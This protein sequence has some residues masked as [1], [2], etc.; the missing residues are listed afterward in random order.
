MLMPCFHVVIGLTVRDIKGHNER[1]IEIEETSKLGQLKHH[2][3]IFMPRDLRKRQYKAFCSGTIISAQKVVSAARCFLTNRKRYRVN[4]SSIQVV[5]AI[6]YTLAVK[7]H[8]DGTQQWRSVKTLYSPRYFRYPAN[9]IALI[10]TCSLSAKE[11][12]GKIPYIRDVRENLKRCLGFPRNDLYVYESALSI[13]RV[14]ENFNVVDRPWVFGQF[15]GS[16]PHA[17]VDLDFDGVCIGIAVRPIT[18][19]SVNSVLYKRYTHMIPNKRCEATLI[20]NL[21]RYICT[22]NLQEEEGES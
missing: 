11:N 3:F 21:R 5:A 18:S 12:V 19:W 14:P 16:V 4:L 15:V 10:I 13:N 20:R 6:L 8:E 2:V 7:P 22:G 1:S 17:S 9:N